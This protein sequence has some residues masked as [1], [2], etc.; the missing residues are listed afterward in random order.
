[1]AFQNL[2]ALYA[3]TENALLFTGVQ[4]GLTGLF[5]GNNLVVRNNLAKSLLYN[6]AHKF[7]MFF[8]YDSYV[9]LRSRTANASYNSIDQHSLL[10]LA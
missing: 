5:I 7:S 8:T 3:P 2:P 10:D 4:A 6:G 9:N 1:M